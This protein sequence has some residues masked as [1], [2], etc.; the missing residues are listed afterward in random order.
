MCVVSGTGTLTYIHNYTL[1]HIP[2]HYNTVIYYT[3]MYSS[4]NILKTII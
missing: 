2:N 1:S 4:S 3:K